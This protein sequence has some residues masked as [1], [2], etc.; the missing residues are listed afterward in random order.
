[1]GYGT[2][3]RDWKLDELGPMKTLSLSLCMCGWVRF[4]VLRDLTH[5]RQPA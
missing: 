1:M 4:L 5:R 2:R 3:P